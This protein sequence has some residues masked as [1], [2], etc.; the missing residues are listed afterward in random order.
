MPV[1]TR[2]RMRPAGPA[3][4]SIRPPFGA[5]KIRLNICK[6]EVQPRFDAEGVPL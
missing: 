3:Y 1:I 2:A 4:A 6:M 5:T